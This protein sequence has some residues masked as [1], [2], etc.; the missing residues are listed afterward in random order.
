MAAA[1]SASETNDKKPS[2]SLKA[3]PSMGFA[4]TRVVVTAEIKGGADDHE[5]FYC[6]EIEWVWGDGT[7]SESNT[8]CSPYEAGKSEIR[9]RYTIEHTFTVPDNYR[10]EF[11]IKKKDKRVAGG[12]TTI[13]V[14]PGLRDGG[15]E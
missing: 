9:R 1:L 5:E 2:I 7:T 4:P 12:K 10:V 15:G 14:R 13:M 11:W 8:D 6:P 3:S